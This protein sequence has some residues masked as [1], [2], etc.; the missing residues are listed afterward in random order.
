[1]TQ[2]GEREALRWHAP[3]DQTRGAPLRWFI[4]LA[5]RALSSIWHFIEHIVGVVHI[6]H[7]AKIWL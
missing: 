2:N 1:M 4:A 5:P 7:E 3:V 6:E